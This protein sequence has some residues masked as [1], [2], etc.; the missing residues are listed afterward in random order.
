MLPY[1][2]NLPSHTA[3]LTIDISVTLAIGGY[4]VIPIFLVATW[5][6]IT[7]WT[8]VPKTTVHKNNGPFASECE[9][10]LAKDRLVATPSCNPVPPKYF[11]QFQL[12][13]FV[14]A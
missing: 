10:G 11:D 2:N 12:G 13:R 4:F 7:L 8:T 5:S 3:Q 1:A 9:V 14:T 6:L